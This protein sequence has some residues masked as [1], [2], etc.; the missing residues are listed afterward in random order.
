MEIFGDWFW[1]ACL[2]YQNKLAGRKAVI[3][4]NFGSSVFAEV[5]KHCLASLTNLTQPWNVRLFRLLQEN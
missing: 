5:I 3:C 1:K 2:A 4:Y